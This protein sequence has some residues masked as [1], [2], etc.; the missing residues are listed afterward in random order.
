VAA[1]LDLGQRY[2]QAGKL[3]E[4][5]TEYLAA[6]KL[7]PGNLEASTSLGL[8]LFE[9]GLPEQGLKSVN[10]A[11]AGDPRYPEALY[12]K[13]II[14]FMGM[15]QPAAAVDAFKAY[16]SAAPFGSHRDAVQQLL[17]L[18][19]ANQAPPAQPPGP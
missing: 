12:A 9:S 4:A 11:L 6:V 8:L 14:L 16:L 2:Q 17:A 3:R 15:R 19:S 1:R 10:K 13:G 18:A 7:E 5:T